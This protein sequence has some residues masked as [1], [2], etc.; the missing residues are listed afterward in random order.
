LGFQS[1]TAW[2]KGSDSSSSVEAGMMKEE[3]RTG[4]EGIE[5][6]RRRCFELVLWGE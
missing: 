3:R 4:A 5:V 2:R 1:D 6:D